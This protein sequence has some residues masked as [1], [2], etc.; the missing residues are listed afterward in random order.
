M[1]EAMVSHIVKGTGI[2][3]PLGAG[4]PVALPVQVS[5]GPGPQIGGGDVAAQKDEPVWK[6]AWLLP[7]RERS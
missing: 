7:P 1:Q 5:L 3:A 4:G 2:V 6:R